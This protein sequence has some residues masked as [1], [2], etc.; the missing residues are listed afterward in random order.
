MMT[1][2][3]I[4]DPVP[5][6]VYRFV[7]RLD[8]PGQVHVPGAQGL[9]RL[10]DGLFDAGAHDENIVIDSGLFVRKLSSLGHDCPP[11]SSLSRDGP[12]YSLRSRVGGCHENIP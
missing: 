8:E 1:G 4:V 11:K 9:Q 10:A 12:K 2:D 7:L 6:L 3:L 5:E